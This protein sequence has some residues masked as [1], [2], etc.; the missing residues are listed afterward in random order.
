MF[1]MSTIPGVNVPK[2][3]NVFRYI[4]VLYSIV[5]LLF[6][7]WESTACSRQ[8]EMGLKFAL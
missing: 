7:D 6:L 5:Y 8:F 2:R 1:I 3:I 4:S